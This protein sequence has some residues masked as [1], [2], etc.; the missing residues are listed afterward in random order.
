LANNI[1]IWVQAS[2]PKTLPAAT[3]P[4]LLGVSLA[5]HDGQFSLLPAAAT[6]LAALLIQIGTNLANDLFDFLKGAD[7][8]ERVGPT[9]VTQAGLLSPGQVR[10]GTIIVFALAVIIGF[11]LAFIGGWPIVWIG[12]ASIAAGVAY[13]GGPYPLGYHGWG[14]IFVLLFFGLIAVPGTFYLQTGFVSLDSILL[15]VAMGAVSTAILVVNNLRDIDTDAKTGKK[16]LA[17]RFGALFVRIEYLLM[18]IIA[19]LIPVFLS[20]R[21]ANDLAIYLVFFSFPVAVRMCVEV[22]TKNG[23]ELFPILGGTARVL[24][25]YSLLLALGMVL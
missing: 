21:W 22:W 23:V 24:M 12:L 1:S 6:M 17:V 11:Y 3:A 4:V 13:T 19:Y 2:R 16:T 9:R 14:D 8:E 7:T 5:F 10:N 25:L 20:I 18:L 15:G